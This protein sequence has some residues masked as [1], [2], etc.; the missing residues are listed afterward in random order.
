MKLSLFIAKH[1]FFS[2]KSTNVINLISLIS[3]VGIAIG[4]MAL[5]VILS[6]FNG[7]EE[8]I[9]SRYNAFDADFRVE[10]ISGKTF[11]VDNNLLKEILDIDGVNY[12]I[13]IVEENALVKYNDKYYPAHLKGI[14]DD[15]VSMSGMDTMIIYGQ[16]LLSVDSIPTAVTGQSLANI[17][18]IQINTLKPL[19]IYVPRRLKKVTM[20]PDEAFK[21]KFI[22]PVGTFSVEPEIDNFV[23]LPVSFVTQLLDYDKNQITALEITVTKDTKEDILRQ[24]LQKILGDEI[25]IKNRF[26]QHQFIYKIMRTEK[27]IVFFILA[28]I[29]LIASFNIVG[30][31]TMLIIEKQKDIKTFN[32]LGMSI[33]KIKMIFLSEGLLISVIGAI[34][35]LIFGFV[36]CLLQIRFGLIKLDGS[37]NNAFIIQAYPISMHLTDFLLVAITVITIGYVAARYPVRF[38]VRKYFSLTHN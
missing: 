16:F 30:S 7:L 23:L 26:Q 8:V 12:A 10:P 37:Q 35:G 36:F 5:I 13:P 15:F 2:K 28:L 3:I 33:K 31:L 1:Y 20:N 32:A 38:I 14:T 6:V 9:I 4:S 18:G 22:V 29:L 27:V 11:N 24:S 19:Q 25:T 21:R 17:L 34:L